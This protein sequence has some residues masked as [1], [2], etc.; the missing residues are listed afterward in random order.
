[1]SILLASTQFISSFMPDADFQVSYHPLAA[2][3]RYWEVDLLRGIA[4]ILMLFYHLAFDLNYFA[5][6]KIDI[7]SGLP[8][9]VARTAAALFL[10]IVGLSLALSRSRAVKLGDGNGYLSHLTGRALFIWAIALGI[11][12]V[13]YLFLGKC[14]IAF[15]VLHLIG[16]SLLLAYP[17]LRMGRMNFIFGIVA[18][19]IGLYL[20][21]L[22]V[23]YPWLLWLGLAPAS[24]CSVDYT[25]VFPWFGFVLIGAAF[26]DLLY[27]GYQRRISLP[28][29]R[30]S[31]LVKPLAFLGRHSLAVYLIHQPA[32]LA[33]FYLLGVRPIWP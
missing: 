2:G 29:F 13:T 14:F 7:V 22:H 32:I 19:I 31:S 26:G 4:L 30:G 23:S 25:P 1:M 20:S 10:T 28:D 17:F 9:A 5:V 16:L 3:S 33:L 21:S 24:F 18:V 11:S 27:P 6:H 12:A 15:G 8:L